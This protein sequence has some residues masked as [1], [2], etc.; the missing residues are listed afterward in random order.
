MSYGFDF[1]TQCPGGLP[2]VGF[3]PPCSFS[4]TSTH[5]WEA[6]GGSVEACTRRESGRLSEDSGLCSFLGGVGTSATLSL[7][8]LVTV[9]GLIFMLAFYKEIT[10]HNAYHRGWYTVPAQ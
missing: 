1:S 2:Q 8:S 7:G 3:I 9:V 6:L 4:S 5:V 10:K